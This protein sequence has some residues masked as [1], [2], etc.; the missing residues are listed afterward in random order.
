METFDPFL[1][2]IQ[3]HTL[4]TKAQVRELLGPPSE[5]YPVQRMPLEEWDYVV[6]VD[7]RF[8]DYLVRFSSDGIVRDAYL[9]HDPIY[10]GGDKN[11]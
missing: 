6:L 4:L 10:D 7:N 2:A 5:I 3:A 9:L 8:F 11:G 1:A